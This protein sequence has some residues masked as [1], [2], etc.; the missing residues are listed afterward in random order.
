[1]PKYRQ[2]ASTLTAIAILA[3]AYFAAGKLGLMLA[4]GNPNATAVWA[5][6]GIA[7]A[8]LLIFGYRLWP[9]VALGAL[10]VNLATS[11]SVAASG[12]I[13]VGNTAEVLVAAWLIN[14]FAFGRQVF[15]RAHSTFLFALFAAM[16]AALAAVI[17]VTGLVWNG[18]AAWTDYGVVWF[19]WWLGDIS[20]AL[21]V[22]PAILLWVNSG[23]RWGHGRIAETIVFSLAV[24]VLGLLVFGGWSRLSVSNY[25]VQFLILPGVLWFAYRF[26]P[27]EAAT[28]VLVLAGMAIAGIFEGHGP[29][30]GYPST[31]SFLLTQGFMSVV[32]II[33]LMLATAVAEH[34]HA[35]D[36]QRWL[37]TIVE[38]STDAIIG[39]TLDGTIL[40][41][42]Q[43]A[44]RM[45]GYTAQEV[46]GKPAS[47]LVPA[48][49][50]DELPQLLERIARGERVEHYETTRRCKDGR[51]INVSLTI[52]PI[53]DADGV[54]RGAS[55]IERD[56]TE[57]RRT[58][59]RIR[60][61]AQHDALT[62]LPN[63]ILF[64][65]RIAQAIVQ[66]RRNREQLGVLFLDLDGFK[67]I[68]DS[69]GHQVGD[70][71]LRMTARR[72]QR[73]VRDGDSVARLGG[74]EFV[75]SL[76]S[77]SESSDAMMIAGKVLE[78]LR[79]PFVVEQH[80]LHLSG[81]VGISVYP[82]DGDDAESLMRAADIAMYHAKEKGRNNYQ[83]FT[84]GLNEAAQRRLMIANRLHQAWQRGELAVDY[85]PQVDLESNRIFSTEA[86]L[87]WHQSDIGHISPNEF[88]R[89]A[90][91]TGL[92]APIGE[93]VLRQACEQLRRWRTAGFSDLRVAV[94]LSPQQFRR[95]GFADLVRD[96]LHDA[97]L[98][99][100]LLEMEITE[101]VLM[102]QSAEN[103][104]IL[105]QLAETGV[106]LAVDDFG[107]GYSS[108]SYLQRFPVHTL[109]IDRSFVDGIGADENDTAIVT[110]IIA[111]AHSLRLK[112]VAEGV[113]T[114]DQAM[115]L[116]SHG[117]LAAQGFFYSKPVNA[118]QLGQLLRQP[119]GSVAPPME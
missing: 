103:L 36:T 9:G 26:G 13:A 14:R 48:Y 82:S 21:L 116:R 58:E 57:R 19:T 1:M 111:M 109:K 70:R 93:W 32:A 79:E 106:R 66:A 47:I 55:A 117:C 119:T 102:T 101:G 108:L 65:D 18:L 39:K 31:E 53:K 71:V 34:R 38:S 87:R 37:A 114:A 113:E 11:G 81:S 3:L 83:F 28:A 97:R 92:I 80:E 29:F 91:E 25:P 60:F 44:E 62:G 49:R 100:E 7:L 72:L 4:F 112:V 54:I 15:E 41:W 8:A 64:S 98:S 27:R 84:S 20:G 52:S 96:I 76:P 88:V 107:T 94:N 73:C 115:F 105:E 104:A 42:N 118:L 56:I 90:E 99:P 35:A 78:S 59:E 77:L 110:A 45:Y 61:L 5:P 95:P 68:N 43:G 17:G 67:H 89:V 50:F 85:Q 75:I 63:R 74:D 22:T 46:V 16:G 86:L 33:G 24:V 40:S 10:A 51:R 2:A 12:L 30:G 23:L 69:L 6:A